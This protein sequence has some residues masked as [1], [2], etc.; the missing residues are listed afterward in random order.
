MANVL[1]KVPDSVVRKET[2]KAIVQPG[3]CYYVLVMEYNRLV[4]IF[5][6]SKTDVSYTEK[7]KRQLLTEKGQR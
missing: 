6:F 1:S 5:C 7:T 4:V 2:M 3:E